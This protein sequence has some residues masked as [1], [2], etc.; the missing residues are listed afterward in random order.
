M[1]GVT[2][3]GARAGKAFA[4]G[5][6]YGRLD[7]PEPASGAR[8]TCVAT[9][10]GKRVA[11]RVSTSAEAAACRVSL[12]KAAR[13]KVLKLTLTTTLKGRSVRKSYATRVKA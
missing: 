6:V 9:L 4:A 8:T 10:A 13:G 3:G 2:K 12:P 1:V 7:S 5:Y 11:A